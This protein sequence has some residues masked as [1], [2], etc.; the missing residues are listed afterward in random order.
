ML[1]DPLS[2][3]EEVTLP[4]IPEHQIDL[5]EV[6]ISYKIHDIESIPKSFQNKNPL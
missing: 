4:S 6:P 5:P 2:S 1:Q 3:I